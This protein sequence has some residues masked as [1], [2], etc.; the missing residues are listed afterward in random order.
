MLG[1]FTND[2]QTLDLKYFSIE[3][4]K[5]WRYI[6]QQGIDSFVGE[7]RG[8]KVKLSFD[9]SNMGYANNLI[10]TPEEYIERQ[11][12]I[13]YSFL[14]NKPDVHYTLGKNVK[15]VKME[16]MKKLNTTDS[17]LVKVEPFIRPSTKIYLPTKRDLGKF[18]DA[19]YLIDLTYKDSTITVGVTLPNDIRKHNIKIDTI[20]QYVIKTIWPK[21]TGEGIT[22]VYYRKINSRFDLQINGKNL[23]EQQ[24]GEALRAFKTIQIRE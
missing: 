10:Q 9:C 5:K 18:K 8:P 13:S 19:D 7:I 6:R 16:E 17:S 4:P 20:G 15:N 3:V 23:G 2:S 12:S 1:A 24:Q 11:V 22:G 21:K 14:F